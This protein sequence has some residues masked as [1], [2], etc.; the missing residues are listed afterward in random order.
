MAISDGRPTYHA[1][2]MVGLV[3]SCPTYAYRFD[4]VDGTA[5]R[6]RWLLVN[7]SDGG[8]SL[9]RMTGEGIVLHESGTDAPAGLDR[10]GIARKDV[11]IY[12]K[13]N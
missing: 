6:V 5:Q 4:A 10:L 11:F 7:A 3:K 2:G 12:G 8:W 13:A 9:Y 1:Y